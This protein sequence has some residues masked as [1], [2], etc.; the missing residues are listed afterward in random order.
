M[1]YQMYEK[2]FDNIT[3]QEM[4]TKIS[5][6]ITIYSTEWLKLKIPSVDKESNIAG[7]IVIGLN[8]LGNWCIHFLIK[9][10]SLTC[11]LAILLCYMCAK[12][13][14]WIFISIHSSLELEMTQIE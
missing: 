3:S 5:V 12:R 11:D 7:G 1:A 10:I 13:C 6:N 14:T 4:Q 9:L 2:V 8:T